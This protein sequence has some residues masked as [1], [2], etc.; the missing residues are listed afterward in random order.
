MYN[1]TIGI[2]GFFWLACSVGGTYLGAFGVVLTSL[3]SLVSSGTTRL[4]LA[5]MEFSDFIFY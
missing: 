3:D 5:M 2:E 1:P 4:C